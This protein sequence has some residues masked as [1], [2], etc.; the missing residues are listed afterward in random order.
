MRVACYAGSWNSF[1]SRTILPS[2][3]EALSLQ[4]SHPSS[5]TAAPSLLLVQELEKALSCKY[6]ASNAVTAL[7]QVYQLMANTPQQKGSALQAWARILLKPQL[8]RVVEACQLLEQVALDSVQQGG[9]YSEAKSKQH[10]LITSGCVHS[11][12]LGVVAGDRNS[13]FCC[14]T[15]Y[16]GQRSWKCPC[17]C[18]AAGNTQ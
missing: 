16:V 4:L 11:G 5:V 14:L 9:S 12:H 7:Q 6:V 13:P 2:Q 10:L 18:I 15:L 17:L 1:W 3:A 8:G